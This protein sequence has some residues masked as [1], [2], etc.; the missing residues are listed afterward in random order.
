MVINPIVGV[1]IPIIR[2][3][4]K[5]WDDHPQYSDFWPWHM[6]QPFTSSL[7]CPISSQCIFTWTPWLRVSNGEIPVGRPLDAPMMQMA[8]T[9]VDDF[10]CSIRF[11]GLMPSM[12]YIVSVQRYQVRSGQ[13]C[14]SCISCM[15]CMSYRIFCIDILRIIHKKPLGEKFSLRAL[16]SLNA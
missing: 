2:I 7:G 11:I 9:I 6:W 1:Y 3:P 10:C 4:I 5:R 12:W 14:W 13:K 8:Q 15:S 16:D